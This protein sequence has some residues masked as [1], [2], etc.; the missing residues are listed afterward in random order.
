MALRD[1]CLS[2][3]L[4]LAPQR[5]LSPAC[6]VPLLETNKRSQD[7]R[8]SCFLWLPEIGEEEKEYRSIKSESAIFSVGL[9]MCPS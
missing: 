5:P 3:C 4:G 6:R 9:G 7:V 2:V 1:V 8:Y